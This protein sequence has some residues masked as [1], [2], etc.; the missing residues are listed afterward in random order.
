M[1]RSVRWAVVA[2]IAVL[3]AVVGVASASP[4]TELA[5]DIVRNGEPIGTHVMRIRDSGRRTEVDVGTD[6]VFKL[7][8]ITVYTFRHR[9]HEL[10]DDG[11]LLALTSDTDDN[12]KPSHL[13]IERQDGE[14][15]LLDN[16]KQT[17]PLPNLLPASLWNPAT[18]GST[19]LLD[20]LDGTLMKIACETVGDD[21]VEVGGTRL[22]AK[23]YRISGDLRRELW[24]GL[25]GHLLAV[26][27]T[28]RDGS[29][30]RYRLRQAPAS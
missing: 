25:H 21:V 8:A 16:D 24:Y 27:F 3:T 28:A 22:P 2:N 4:V 10:W 30:I 1:V 20:T 12:G 18:V 7:L 26:R 14:L 15:V 17:R 29:E 13:R 5:Y 6:I 23:G 11:R 9:S 19:A